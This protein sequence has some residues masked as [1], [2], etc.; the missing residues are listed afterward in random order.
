MKKAL[1]IQST[2]RVFLKEHSVEHSK[3]NL[4]YVPASNNNKYYNFDVIVMC[5]RYWNFVGVSVVDYFRK[6]LKSTTELLTDPEQNIT[7]YL[8]VCIPV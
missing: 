5:V 6:D 4:S 7:I 8:F 2:L 3:N 1:S